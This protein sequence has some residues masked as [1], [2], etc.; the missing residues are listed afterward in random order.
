MRIERIAGKVEYTQEVANAAQV[1]LD[2]QNE[3]TRKMMDKVEKIDEKGDRLTKYIRYFG[4]EMAADKLL[5][6]LCCTIIVLLI[7]LIVA[8]TL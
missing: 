5:C 4:V 8:W 6:C 3:Q 2:R 7:V 1:E